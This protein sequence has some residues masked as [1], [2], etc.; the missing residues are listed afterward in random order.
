MVVNW[1][2]SRHKELRRCDSVLLAIIWTKR[3]SGRR[4]EVVM[5]GCGCH[6][7]ASIHPECVG[8]GLGTGTWWWR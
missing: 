3:G 1:G 7:L 8:W 4:A 2:S 5:G 6:V